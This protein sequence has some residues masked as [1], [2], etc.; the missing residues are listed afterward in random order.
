MAFEWTAPTSAFGSV[1]RK[2]KISL[3][4]SPSFTFGT[5][6]QLVQMPAKQARGQ[7]RSNPRAVSR[8]ES[9]CRQSASDTG[10]LSRLSGTDRAQWLRVSRDREHGF[11]RIVSSDFRR[12]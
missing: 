12:S 1:V 11:Q 3:V 6:V 4:V 10:R 7:P 2:A 9:L 5:D 8:R